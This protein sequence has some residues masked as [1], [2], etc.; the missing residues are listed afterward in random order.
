METALRLSGFREPLGLWRH[1]AGPPSQQ[2]GLRAERIEYSSRGDRATGRLWL[3]RHANGEV[4]VVLIEHRAGESAA[5][6]EIEAIALRVAQRGA[7]VVAI[8]FPLHGGRGDAKLGARLARALGGE[9]DA[10]PPDLVQEFARQAVVDLERALDA[11]GFMPELDLE[12]VGYVGLGVGARIGAAFAALDARVRAVALAF[13][14][15]GDATSTVDAGAFVA[16]IA[17]RPLLL[18]HAGRSDADGARGAR[19]L[20]EAAGDPKQ[21]SRVGSDVPGDPAVQHA[22]ERFLVPALGLPDA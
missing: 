2:P 1:R 9:R 3:P 8:D 4:P 15:A 10:A 14:G 19:A 20:F 16:R 22:L 18:I 13:P 11:C 6:S 12:R 7:A 17:P 5:S 21:E